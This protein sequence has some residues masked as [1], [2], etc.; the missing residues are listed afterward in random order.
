MLALAV[1]SLALA[2]EDLDP[3]ERA[4]R[5]SD[6][7]GELL[8]LPAGSDDWITFE[9]NRPLLM[10]DTLFTQGDARSE[11]DLGTARLWLDYASGL[12]FTQFDPADVGAALQQGNLR[13][14]KVS[15]ADTLTIAAGRNV[16]VIIEGVAHGRVDRSD[17]GLTVSLDEGSARIKVGELAYDLREGE[18][19]FLRGD[20][21]RV[22]DDIRSGDAFDEWVS[23]RTTPPSESD[24][25]VA[26]TVAGRSD[27]DRYGE[28]DT[29]DDYG[30]IWYP[31]SVA[32]GW[33]PYRY[34]HWIATVN[35]GWTWV[36][37]APWGYTPFHY[38]RWI[39][40]GTRWGWSPGQRVMHVAY[41]PA[42]VVFL[43][44][45][46]N[47]VTWAP[48]GYGQVYQPGF[49][50][51]PRYSASLHRP[52]AFARPV[53]VVHAGRYS[54][55]VS[56]EHFGGGR[57][58][59]HEVVRA[60]AP[61]RV[62]D[63]APV[64]LPRFVRPVQSDPIANLVRTPPRL[65]PRVQPEQPRFERPAV[66]DLPQALPRPAAEAPRFVRPGQGSLTVITPPP[67]Q[68]TPPRELWSPSRALPRVDPQT[69][70]YVRP[71]PTPR[72]VPPP[73][74]ATPSVSPPT[75]QYVRPAPAPQ[76]PR[77]QPAPQLPRVQPAPVRVQPPP[78]PVRMLPQ[79]API[80]VQPQTMPRVQP[81]APVPRMVPPAATPPRVQP[82]FRR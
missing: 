26:P 40:V 30:A 23:A 9:R 42:L 63:R 52:W 77:V 59:Q 50:C 20:A 71:D 82:V 61:V 67:R 76:L 14:N 46:A 51:S 66:R 19:F 1:L 31:T 45:L 73:S 33:Q 64:D 36:D 41:A 48:L 8:L 65:A 47:V 7:S 39:L 75:P 72:L 11:I 38:G 68:V 57:S 55:S 21:F 53:D 44:T 79:A 78:A 24:Q 12:A 4:A 27:L 43:S 74:V 37:D 5:V 69:P 18:H 70:N 29:S 34:G 62:M 2:A 22:N 28:W 60:A 13:F 80:R 81:A 17:Q 3:P 32:A 6:T 54:T 56:S 10:G 25:Y 58:V 49:R 16:S 15:R 35:Y